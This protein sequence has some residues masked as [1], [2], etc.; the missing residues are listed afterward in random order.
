[1]KNIL[2]VFI[3]TFFLINCSNRQVN[4]PV[5][6][7]AIV[8]NNDT[9]IKN[10][11]KRDTALEETLGILHNPFRDINNFDIQFGDRFIDSLHVLYSNQGQTKATLTKDICIGD[12]CESYKTIVN[13]QENTV[14]YLFKGDGSEYGFSN[15]QFYLSKDSLIYARNFSVSVDTWPTDSSHTGWKIQEIVYYLQ[16]EKPCRKTRTA[17]TAELDKFDF[18]L[19][20][21]TP[22]SDNKVDFEKIYQE[23]SIELEKLL[24]MKDSENRD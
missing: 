21:V 19:R 22:E 15:D 18:T 14:L 8:Q 23:K 10:T 24:E 11:T 9:A 13:K 5:D 6:N 17:Y 3:G 16:A 20:S 1:M 2:L 4:N 7:N 12:N